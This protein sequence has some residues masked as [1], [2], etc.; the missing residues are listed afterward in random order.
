M[1][2]RLEAEKLVDNWSQL[3]LADPRSLIHKQ[4]NAED[5]R[6]SHSK[7][8]QRFWILRLPNRVKLSLKTGKVAENL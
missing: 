2:R 1:V 7:A 8:P 4:T 3:I 5:Q 6:D